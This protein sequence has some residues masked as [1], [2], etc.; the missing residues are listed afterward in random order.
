MVAIAARPSEDEEEA[1]Q[2]DLFAALTKKNNPFPEAED[3]DSEL[4]AKEAGEALADF[5]DGLLEQEHPSQTTAR[6]YAGLYHSLMAD[7]VVRNRLPVH[8]RLSMWGPMEARLLSADIV[9]LGALNEG[10]WPQPA[11]AD[12]WLSRPMRTEV[13]LPS[14]ERRI[15]RSAHDMSQVLGCQQGLSDQSHKNRWRALCALALAVA[16]AGALQRRWYRRQTASSGQ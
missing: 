6:E 14:P 12:A 10:S 5:F 4:W 16:Y 7:Q 8:P 2:G 11:D 3:E 1:P 15:G 13:G 9:V